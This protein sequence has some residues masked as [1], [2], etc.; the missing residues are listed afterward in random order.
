MLPL[1]DWGTW[2]EMSFWGVDHRKPTFLEL[3]VTKLLVTHGTTRYQMKDINIIFPMIPLS[4]LWVKWFGYY[5]L[6][7]LS[8]FSKCQKS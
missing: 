6:S 8:N 2:T 5:S 4:F 7:K 3:F 1:S